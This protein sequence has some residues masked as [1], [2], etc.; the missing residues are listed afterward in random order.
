M[1]IN[2]DVRDVY[3]LQSITVF[4]Y[5]IKIKLLVFILKLTTDIDLN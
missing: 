4:N 2:V 1:Q 3:Q 5:Y